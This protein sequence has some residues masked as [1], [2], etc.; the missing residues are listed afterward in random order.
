MQTHPP[1]RGVII[2]RVFL[3]FMLAYFLSEIFRNVNGVVGPVLQ[4]DLGLDAAALGALTSTFFVAVAASQL[5]VGILLDRFGARRTVATLLVF[6][7]AGNA[8][9][10][11]GDL[12]LMYLGRFMVGLGVAGCW[13]AAFKVNAQWWSY[14]HLAFANGAIIGCAGLGALAATVPTQVLLSIIPWQELFLW[15]AGATLVV[16]VGLWVWAMDHPSDRSDQP[17]GMVEALRG[18]GAVLRNPVFVVFGPISIVGQGVWLSYQGLW[19]GAW[20]REVDGLTPLAAAWFLLALATCVV[21]GNFAMGGVASRLARRGVTTATVTLGICAGF[22][23]VQLAIW[24]NALAISPY[25]W[26]AFGFLVSG[27]ILVYAI[28]STA[29]P[30]RYGGR[31]VSLLNLFATLA[32]FLIQYGV[33]QIIDL[34]PVGSDGNYPMVAHQVAFGVVIAGQVAALAWLLSRWRRVRS[35]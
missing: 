29:M 26:S 1:S 9:F 14:E 7:V 13:T 25:L 19:A 2:L 3:P 12:L 16:T 15:M 20:L 27:P 31:A 17:E 35:A 6:A 11:T 10:A 22:V 34:W 23:A 30:V 8:L 32:G 24:T 5:F 4:A 21:L 28:L 18:F 33:G